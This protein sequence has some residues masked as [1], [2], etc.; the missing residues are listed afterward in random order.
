MAP[1]YMAE[2][3]I[4]EPFFDIRR[5]FSRA[6]FDAWRPLDVSPCLSNR[7]VSPYMELQLP[8]G[9]TSGS[10]DATRA[11][12]FTVCAIVQPKVRRLRYV[13]AE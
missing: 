6:I 7:V 4:A 11:A 8:S 10:R 3:T 13:P 12:A 5:D 9:A 2:L 1:R